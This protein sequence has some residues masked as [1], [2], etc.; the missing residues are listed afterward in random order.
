MI[1]QPDVL[2][3]LYLYNSSFSEQVKRINYDFYQP[4]TIHESSLS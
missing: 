3:M 4:R 1:K 2:M